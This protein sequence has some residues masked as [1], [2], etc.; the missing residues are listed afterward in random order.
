MICTCRLC[1]TSP[2][3][4]HADL[5]ILQQPPT[6]A[7]VKELAVPRI[8][9]KWFN[10]GTWCGVRSEALSV[11]ERENAGDPIKCCLQMFIFW[12]YKEPETEYH[13]KTWDTL[14]AAVKKAHGVQTYE[15]IMRALIASIEEAEVRWEGIMSYRFLYRG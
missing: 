14:L 2:V 5:G 13:P 15:N 3:F 7:L 10:V 11:I 12:L 8:A 9:S 6:L 4:L 1:S